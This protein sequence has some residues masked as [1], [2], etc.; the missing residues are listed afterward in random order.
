MPALSAY[1]IYESNQYCGLFTFKREM[2]YFLRCC[3]M[4]GNMKVQNYIV[5]ILHKGIILH[6][7][8]DMYI[9][10]AV[11]VDIPERPRKADIPRVDVSTLT[12]V[13]KRTCYSYLI[14]WQ[15]YPGTGFV[16]EP[17]QGDTSKTLATFFGNVYKFII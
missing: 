11:S 5:L 2:L 4:V 13:N 15:V 10:S 7:Q 9:Q 14:H 1:E 17:C 3:F 12:M 6:E 16:L 8:N